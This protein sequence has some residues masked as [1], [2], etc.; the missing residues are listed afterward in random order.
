MKNPRIIFWIRFEFLEE[1]QYRYIFIGNYDRPFNF[2]FD[3]IDAIG[4]LTISQILMKLVRNG[5]SV[6][7]YWLGGPSVSDILQ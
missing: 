5:P 7:V 2:N 3:D 1:F 4:N 6:T